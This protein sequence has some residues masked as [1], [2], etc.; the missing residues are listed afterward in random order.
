MKWLF[1]LGILWFYITSTNA[2]SFDTDEKTCQKCYKYEN[3]HCLSSDFKQGHCCQYIK[4]SEAES[5]CML[6]FKYCTKN[7]SDKDSEY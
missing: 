7:M 1:E 3:A 2:N 5:I 4:E 6:K